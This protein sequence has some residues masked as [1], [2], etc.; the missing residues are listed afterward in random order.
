MEEIKEIIAGNIVSYRTSM[1]L[2]QYELAQKLNYS[3]KSVSKWERGQG[4]PDIVVLMKLAGLFGVSVDE[5]LKKHE[6]TERIVVPSKKVT[7]AKKILTTLMA[8]G[9]VWLVATLV[10]VILNLVGVGG[11]WR[12]FVYAVPVTF[13]VALIFS[14]IWGK[15]WCTA[16]FVSFFIWT[17]LLSVYITFLKTRAWLFFFIGIPLQVLV[18]LGTILLEFD[19]KG[20]KLK[21]FTK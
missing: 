21:K 18:V 3:D 7:R 20:I 13:L 5:L 1:G 12:V 14:A 10:Y 19:N 9:L 6:Q 17:T 16:I 8:C 2:T 15:K 4:L 11:I